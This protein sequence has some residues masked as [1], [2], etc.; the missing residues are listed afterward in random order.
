MSPSHAYA[1]GGEYTV[2][3]IVNDGK[4][5]ST[6]ST[7]I[8]NITEVNDPPVP[9]AGPERV[10]YVD[11]AV[12]FD[13]SASYDPDGP[14]VSYAWDFGDGKS[15]S[16]ASVKHTY[17]AVGTYTVTLT[18]TDD[19]GAAAKDLAIVTVANYPGKRQGREWGRG[20]GDGTVR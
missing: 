7:T 20:K 18:V 14:I 12:Q 16:E 2:T 17:T 19:L 9:D 1:A 3:L 10:A 11:S 8:V 15:A 4:A 13:G 6:P 5:N